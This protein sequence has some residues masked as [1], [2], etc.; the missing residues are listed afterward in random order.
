M[1][2]N[3]SD[4]WLF[5]PAKGGLK[6]WGLI[7]GE[8][9][10]ELAEPALQFGMSLVGHRGCEAVANNSQCIFDQELLNKE[11]AVVRFQTPVP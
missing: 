5:S 3:Q 10:E 8:D 9:R 11:D 2:I 7:W 6:Q 1:T 4:I